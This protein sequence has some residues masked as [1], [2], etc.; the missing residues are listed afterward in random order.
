[1]AASVT[2]S[3]IKKLCGKAPVGWFYGHVQSA[4]GDRSR[5]IVATEYKRKGLRLLYY[6]DDYS[7]DLPFWVPYPAESKGEESHS[8]PV[9]KKHDSSDAPVTKDEEEGLLIL[10]YSHDVNDYK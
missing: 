5:A 10:P 2:L 6:S 9:E 7:D 4:A 8:D 1:V 3:V